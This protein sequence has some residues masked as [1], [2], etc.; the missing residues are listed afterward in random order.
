M[1]FFGG[2]FGWFWFVGVFFGGG[3][4]FFFVGSFECL[5]FLRLLI[6]ISC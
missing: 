2:L 1:G 3:V 4:I 5:G 6:Q